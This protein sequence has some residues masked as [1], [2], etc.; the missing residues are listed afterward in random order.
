MR[1]IPQTLWLVALKHAQLVFVSVER[2][3][4]AGFNYNEMQLIYDSNSLPRW[5]MG[6]R[7]VICS[8]ASNTL[9]LESIFLYFLMKMQWHSISLV[10]AQTW[11]IS[12]INVKTHND[13][14]EDQGMEHQQTWQAW[15][16]R[17]PKS[18]SS[19]SQWWNNIRCIRAKSQQ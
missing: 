4:H 12:S 15:N 18:D 10:V 2:F 13:L 8:S 7:K 9:M 19:Y 6:Q 5:S 1:N 16:Q 17:V 11:F 3:L 14:K